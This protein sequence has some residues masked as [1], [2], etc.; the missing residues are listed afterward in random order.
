M[1]IDEA[2]ELT[3][4]INAAFEGRKVTH[5][6][7]GISQ[8]LEIRRGAFEEAYTVQHGNDKVL[9]G[10]DAC[11]W[12]MTCAEQWEVDS[13]RMMLTAFTTNDHGEL[14][15]FC[16]K[17]DPADVERGAFDAI[18]TKFHAIHEVAKELP[19]DLID[20]SMYGT[21]VMK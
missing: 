13:Y 3:A 12:G 18:Q 8:W 21:M 4:A 6:V 10:I 9:V 16:W 5:V 19:R 2:S 1:T 7:H 20:L 14:R 17:I 15:R 11:G